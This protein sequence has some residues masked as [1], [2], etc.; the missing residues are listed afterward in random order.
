MTAAPQLPVAEPEQGDFELAVGAEP[1]PRTQW[2]LFWRRFL[3]HR[4]AVIGLLVLIGLCIMCFGARWIA[5]DTKNHQN[6]L[7]PASGPS[8][9]HWFGVDDLGRDYFT[10]VLYAGQIS[11]KIGLTVAVIATFVG[12]TVG[13]IAG[14]V[15]RFAD[16]ALMR[17]TDLF[18][19]V[20]Q[21]I[22]LAIAVKYFGSG[23]LPIIL[24]LSGV[25]W[26]YLA[27]IVRGQV[28]SLK[29]K[30]YVEA[31]RA[32]GASRTRIIVRHLVPNMIGPIVVNATL[33]V[34]T[35]I[36]T[37][38]TLSY[39]G[40]GIQPPKTSWGKLISDARD[41]VGTSRAHLMYFPGL[42]IVLVV[43]AINFVGDGL[44]DAFDPQ[45]KH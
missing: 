22:V 33:A 7:R 40:F 19:V 24:V 5:P 35:A 42:C 15:G 36:L 12:V 11:L 41:T 9:Q 6:L 44:R 34:A 25:F 43:L 38:S 31:A 17:V 37:E 18:L 2:E 39:L 13:S 8:A 16:Q 26:M 45:A 27:R 32:A 10:E 30:E 14:Y 3:R 4:L 1:T 23:D 28:L 21:L 20:P 29:E